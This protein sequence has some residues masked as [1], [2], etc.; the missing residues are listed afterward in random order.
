MNKEQASRQQVTCDYC[1][2]NMRKKNL[3]EHTTKIHGANIQ[4]KE[5]VSM[6]QKR[7]EFCKRPAAIDNDLNVCLY[8]CPSV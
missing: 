6:G 5:K 1:G 8:I 7:L 3:K 4:R 2:V